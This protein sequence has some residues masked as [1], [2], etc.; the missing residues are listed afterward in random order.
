MR[1]LSVSQL[2]QAPTAPAFQ[3]EMLAR[4][5][6]QNL[7]RGAN[8]PKREAWKWVCASLRTSPAK[9]WRSETKTA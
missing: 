6:K 1:V 3:S 5:P 4:P 7:Q 9:T 8:P 2:R